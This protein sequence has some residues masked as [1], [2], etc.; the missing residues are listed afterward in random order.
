MNGSGCGKAPVL[1]SGKGS[2]L[3]GSDGFEAGG[4]GITRSATVLR[5]AVGGGFKGYDKVKSLQK[6]Q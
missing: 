5:L 3:L 4:M 6:I 2:V 1:R